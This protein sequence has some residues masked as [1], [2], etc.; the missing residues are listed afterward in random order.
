MRNIFDF[1]QCSSAFVVDNK[2]LIKIAIV[3]SRG[4]VRRPI[5]PY[6]RSSIVDRRSSIITSLSIVDRWCFL[7]FGHRSL[8]VDRRSLWVDRRSLW[9]SIV[10]RF[11]VDRRS[12]LSRSSV[13]DRE[14]KKKCN[15]YFSDD[16]DRRCFGVKHSIRGRTTCPKPLDRSNIRAL[17]LDHVFSGVLDP[18]S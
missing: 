2:W 13:V 1:D 7:L 14:L 18:R 9:G 17:I 5:M 16:A 15:T 3:E 10:D 6:L 8:W 12:L 11:W 4:H